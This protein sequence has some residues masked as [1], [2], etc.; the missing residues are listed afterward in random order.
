MFCAVAAVGLCLDALAVGMALGWGRIGLSRGA[1]VLAGAC[2]AVA[3]GF[4]LL[5]GRAAALLP[6]AEGLSVLGGAALAAM[7]LWM[8]G[9]SLTDRRKSGGGALGLLRH[10]AGG[11]RDGSGRIEAAEALPL[12]F[13]LSVDLLGAG[14]AFGTV[15]GRWSL[16]LLVGV[17]HPLLL[18]CGLRLGKRLPP[19]GW[20]LGEC[21]AGAM[22]T[23]VGLLQLL[24]G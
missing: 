15:G 11:D 24:Q 16:P 21:C 10:P 9:K 20:G 12:A 18:W 8:A 4:S 2:P 7:G 5:C 17:G 14:L 6:G 13:A 3:L 19:P 22:L 1:F 23:A